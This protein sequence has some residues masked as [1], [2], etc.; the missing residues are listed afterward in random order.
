MSQVTVKLIDL[1]PRHFGMKFRDM[2]ALTGVYHTPVKS[3]LY[4]GDLRYDIYRGGSDDDSITLEEVDPFEDFP[5]PERWYIQ[6]K[7]DPHG[8]AYFSE[9]MARASFAAARMS[10]PIRLIHM[11]EQGT[12]EVVCVGG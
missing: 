6:T 5:F 7:T 1:A 2:G 10:G 4:F 9:P 12:V 11:T 3:T 8:T